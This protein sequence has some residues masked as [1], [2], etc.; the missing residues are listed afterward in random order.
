MPPWR[1]DGTFTWCFRPTFPCHPW[2]IHFPQD[3][4]SRR[5]DLHLIPHTLVE[6]TRWLGADIILSALS[7]DTCPVTAFEHHLLA[8]A[9][10]PPEHGLFSYMH[11]GKPRYM[12]KLAFLA[13]CDSIWSAVGLEKVL[14]HSFRIGG[15]SEHVDRGLAF[16]LL[17][18]QGRLTSNA[19]LRYLQ[20]MDNV[21][22]RK[23]R[24]LDRLQA[25][26]K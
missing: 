18:I 2:D 17:Q 10:V 1:I 24:L 8:N 5:P 6:T 23:V 11:Q 22:S 15:A 25:S 21:V 20:K 9:A 16:D 4:C 7:V 13:R 26:R 3:E 14:G 12:T 19:F